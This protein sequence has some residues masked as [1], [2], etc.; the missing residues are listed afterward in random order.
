[1]LTYADAI[2][3]ATAIHAQDASIKKVVREIVQEVQRKDA[4]VLLTLETVQNAFNDA[5]LSSQVLS[6]LAL[7]VQ[8][9][10][11]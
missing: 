9:F 2:E 5:R 6:L 10:K 4:D 11:Y 1:M 3:A 8:N 7:L